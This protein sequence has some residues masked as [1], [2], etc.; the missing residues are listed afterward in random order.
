MFAHVFSDLLAQTRQIYNGLKSGG[1]RILAR[2]P[3]T[4]SAVDWLYKVSDS[5]MKL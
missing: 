4:S 3:D 5:D 2:L 1:A